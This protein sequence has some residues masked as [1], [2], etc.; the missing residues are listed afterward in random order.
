MKRLFVRSGGGLPG[1]DIH[2]GIWDALEMAG[3][4]PTHVSGTSAGAIASAFQAGPMLDADIFHG[5]ISSLSDEQVRV[6]RPLWKLRV[7]WIGWYLD[8]A[9][10]LSLLEHYLPEHFDRL[11]LQLQCWAVNARDGGAVNVARPELARSP[12]E[13]ALASMSICGVFAPVRLLDGNEYFDGGPAMNLPVPA[14]ANDFDEIYLLV[15]T[16]RP[17]SYSDDESMLTRLIHNAHWMMDDQIH[18]TI[19]QARE[20]CRAKVHVIWPDLPTPRGALH[21]DHNLIDQAQLWTEAWIRKEFNAK[22][23]REAQGAKT[24]AELATDEH[25]FSR[26]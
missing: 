20:S 23:L 1:L 2:A 16:G 14:N 8:S 19:A 24:D 5:L 22:A 3:I 26:Q 4:Y 9:P 6:E 10:I 11:T 7:P 17:G 15:A 13:A 18:D 25:G 21:F 12:A